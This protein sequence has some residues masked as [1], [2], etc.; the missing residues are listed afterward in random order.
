MVLILCVTL[1]EGTGVKHDGADEH[2]HHHGHHRHP[3]LVRY[4]ARS[5][6]G[7]YNLFLNGAVVH[8]AHVVL[9]DTGG[10]GGGGGVHGGD[11]MADRRFYMNLCMSWLL[12]VYVRYA[13]IG[14]AAQ[15]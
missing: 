11:N 5:D 7:L 3:L 2:H 6:P 9:H 8:V 4:C 13:A 15:A 10:G 1:A 14:K 12:D